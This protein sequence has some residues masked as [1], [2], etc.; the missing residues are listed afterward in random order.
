MTLKAEVISKVKDKLPYGSAKL[1]HQRLAEKNIHL[2]YQYVWRCMSMSYVDENFDVMH[3]AS[4]LCKE[5][6]EKQAERRRILKFLRD[7]KC[8]ACEVD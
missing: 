5:V 1:I 7:P 6:C 3:E 8:E 4:L 2:S